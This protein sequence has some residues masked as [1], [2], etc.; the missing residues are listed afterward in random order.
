MPV[1][2]ALLSCSELAA[3]PDRVSL[4]HAAVSGPADT[5]VWQPPTTA[6]PLLGPALEV[7]HAHGS[8][9]T[10]ASGKT[11]FVLLQGS[12]LHRE[13]L[14]GQSCVGLCSATAQSDCCFASQFLLRQ[15]DPHIKVFGKIED[16]VPTLFKQLKYPFQISKSALFAVGSPH[17]WPS[18]LA[19]LGW[20]VEL[21]NYSEKAEQVNS[22]TCVCGHVGVCSIPVENLPASPAI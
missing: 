5:A 21:L 6:D 9:L 8:S 10:K 11:K 2:L 1:S 15:V 7:L 20:L 17:T 13:V 12:Q 14:P 3:C 16:E 19:A 22:S 4:R 18:L